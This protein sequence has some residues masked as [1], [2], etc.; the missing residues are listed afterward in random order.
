MLFARLRN[1]PEEE[2]PQLVDDALKDVF[3][4]YTHFMNRLVC[5]IKQMHKSRLSQVV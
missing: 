4:Q 2:I 5:L 3:F 1:V